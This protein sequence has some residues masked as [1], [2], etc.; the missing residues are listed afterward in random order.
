[1][2][3]WNRKLLVVDA[4]VVAGS[5]DT[6]F[7]PLSDI[8]GDRNRRCLDAIWEEEHIAVFNQQ[9]LLEWQN[10]ASPSSA[11]WLQKM[12]LKSR[13]VLEEGEAFSEIC[14]AACDSLSSES[15]GAE[16]RKDTHLIRSALATGQLI[17]SNETRFAQHLATACSSVVELLRLHYAN[18][19]HEGEVCR[20]WI[21][22]G[23]EKELI[24]RIDRWCATYL[25]EA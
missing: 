21:K 5:S 16:L 3:K 22:A 20:L 18:P 15:R 1:M 17:L 14:E 9:L 23:A 4:S 11:L 6:R 24:R 25:P 7:N 12:T 2:S 13:T 8:E 19:A 10:H